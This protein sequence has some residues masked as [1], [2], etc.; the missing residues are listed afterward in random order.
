MATQVRLTGQVGSAGN[1]SRPVAGGRGALTASDGTAIAV[2]ADSNETTADASY[3]DH[4][5]VGKIYVY[6]S[7]DRITWT[8]RA[9][10]TTAVALAEPNQWTAE[11]F[12]D[13]SIGIVYRGTDGTIRYHKV[14]TG[15]W[16]VSASETVMAATAGVA[17]VDFDLH[18]SDANIPVVA[19][20]RSM[21]T[22]NT[23]LQVYLY[24]RRTSDNTWFNGAIQAILAG[25]TPD[26][27]N[28]GVTVSVL[29]GGTAA[30]R[31]VVFA[32]SHGV[33]A[34]ADGGALVFSCLLNESTGAVT[35]V[36]QR[37]TIGAS[38]IPINHG[39]SGPV[40]R[41]KLFTDAA[42]Q[43]NLGVMVPRSG[44]ADPLKMY[45][46]RYTWN[47]TTWANPIPV[48]SMAGQDNPN[49]SLGMGM[50]YGTGGMVFF[51]VWDVAPTDAWYDVVSFMA[52]VEADNTIF[53]SGYNRWA[54]VTPAANH[55]AHVFGN[56]QK[57]PSLNAYD[58]LYYATTSLTKYAL[59]HHYLATVA[60]PLSVT[61]A[62]G[63][64]TA[65]SLPG[66]T[67]SADIGVKYPQSSYKVV[68]QF[69]TDAIFTTNL[70]EYEQPNSK[71]VAV[72]GT[73][74]A[75]VVVPV[76]D[77]LPS[78]LSLPQG[79]WYVRAALEDGVGKRGTWSAAQS[80]TVAHPPAAANLSPAQDA[81]RAYG[82]GSVTFT[83]SFTDPS[84]DDYQTAFQIL[85][86]RASDGAT[87]LDT[88]KVVST[89]S[90][91]SGAIGSAYK[92]TQLKWQIKLW[93]RDNVAGAYSPTV[94]FYT[95][96]AATAS[97]T[98]PA[99]NATV[100]SSNPAVTLTGTCPTG[101]T[102]KLY[103]IS[104]MQGTTLLWDSGLKQAGDKT[105]AF[106]INDAMPAGYLLNNTAYTL[107]AYV[108]DSVGIQ[109]VQTS[110]IFTTAWTLPAT[111]ASITVSTA[112]Y[113]VDGAG[114]VSIQWPDTGRDA[115][116]TAWLVYRKADMIDTNTGTVLEAGPWQYVDAVT[117]V[118][119]AGYD[120]HDLYA[121]AG[122][123]VTYRVSQVVSRFGDVVESTYRTANPV[124][125]IADSYFLIDLST[126]AAFGMSIVTDDSYTDEYE[127]AEYTIAGRGRYV[128]HGD[129]FGLKGTLTV[130]LRN[131]LTQTARQKKRRLELM[132]QANNVLYLRTP[133]GDLYRV[134]PGNIGVTRI[135]G[136]G[137][138]EFCDVQIPYSEVAS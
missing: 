38:D 15:T 97:I 121:P 124:T 104:L 28:Y 75:G 47:G 83:W 48:S 58:M 138:Q 107:T 64:T 136:V 40:R 59:Y 112:S 24:V 42:N 60:A 8:L 77:S 91:Y 133:F 106:T 101:R 116:F 72:V 135:A 128:D 51:Y 30:A 6:T 89:A 33:S 4:T 56:G 53:W 99:N 55:L 102:V 26:P 19:V 65:S 34:G 23:R 81:W 44:N 69:A 94:T 122:Y 18:V 114:Y 125:T 70:K 20:M 117:T 5:G 41:L 130:Q 113:N 131:S 92:D 22:G 2:V 105:G 79:V 129:H 12:T 31:N 100:T 63:S 46:V 78:N 82:S 36:T 71:Y 9:T 3:G 39:L 93:D 134:S 76:S 96:D 61:P 126:K 49:P 87:V 110:I 57:N 84:A 21:T 103:R 86:T 35:S 137:Q 123:S 95:G 66:L 98:T 14:T 118:N 7:A 120:Y 132:K 74:V 43:V 32:T 115:N 45:F 90:S 80:F 37:A 50:S 54:N 67:A 109:S 68:W 88:G 27:E 10:I 11:L 62:A 111:P 16:A 25:Q 13:N 119:P 127:E 73:D 85:V 52:K 1:V 17:P 29:Q 108:V